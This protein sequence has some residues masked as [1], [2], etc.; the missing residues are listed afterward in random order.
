MNCSKL[1]FISLLA[2]AAMISCT[3]DNEINSTKSE[4][5]NSVRVTVEDFQSESPSTR[6]A[7]TVDESGFHFQWADGDA[8]GIYP[9]G[10]D[11]VKFPISSG[12]GSASASF[13]GG[14]WKLRSEY[15]YAAYYPFSADNYKID[16]KALP[17]SFT[18]QTQNGNG[19][20]AHLGAYD[21]LACAATAPDANGGVDLT[22]KHLGA[23]LRLQLTMPKADTYSSVTLESNGTKFVT[24]GTFDL[25]AATPA[26][27]PTAT[28]ST[29][30]INLTNVATTEKNQVVTVYAIVA[31]ANLSANNITVTVH[32]AGQTT[33][34]QTVQGKNFA[35]RSAYNIVVETFPS[36]TNASGEDVSWDEPEDPY[37]GHEYVDLGLPSGLKWATMNVGATT[38]EAY[39]D[40]FAWGET[41]P[42]YTEGHSQDNPCSNWNT[43]KTGYNE[44]NYKWYNVSD[45]SRSLT[46]Y[47]TFSGYGIVDNK[48]TLELADDAA[49]TNWGGSWRMPTMA[50][51][52]ELLNNCTWT[53]TTQNGVNGSMVVSKTN[54]NSIFLPAAGEHYNNILREAGSFGRYWS[55]SL[56]TGDQY[57]AYYIVFYSSR[58]DWD[59]DCRFY[60][61]SVRAVCPQQSNWLRKHNNILYNKSIRKQQFSNEFTTAPRI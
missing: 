15:Q 35:A 59:A 4:Y 55:S 16:Q 6:T 40:Y 53:W 60:G 36:G 32:G 12:D 23:F 3:N 7:Y 27:T 49:R 2:V 5:V 42:Y 48:T 43:G 24:A 14:A 25:T 58:G 9:I 18:G 31:P 8:L 39:G 21:Y 28:S 57:N 50:E 30:T 19:S 56:Y 51:Q 10:G 37:N 38:P 22:M 44:V 46:K 54:G 1:S 47:C 20:T 29:Y 26:I 61:R 34:V 52:E 17:V 45:V 33:Y 11:Q 13:D 41:E